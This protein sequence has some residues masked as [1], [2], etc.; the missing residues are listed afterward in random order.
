VGDSTGASPKIAEVSERTKLGDFVVLREGK[1]LFRLGLGVDGD[2]LKA[3][4]LGFTGVLGGSSD[5]LF[6]I[7]AGDNLLIC[8][9][10]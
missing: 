5:A 1:G 6:V 7:C 3:G 4:D 10:S 8:S 2:I 9:T